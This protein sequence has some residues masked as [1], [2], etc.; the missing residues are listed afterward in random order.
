MDN[1]EDRFV[2]T[3]ELR[4]IIGNEGSQ[5]LGKVS[6]SAVQNFP[7]HTSDELGDTLQ[8]ELDKY[9]GIE[10][11][12]E[13]PETLDDVKLAASKWINNFTTDIVA[14]KCAEYPE[15]NEETLRRA[16]NHVLYFYSSEGELFANFHLYIK[17]LRM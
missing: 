17:A 10:S 1:P 15:Q 8:V 3:P 9:L 13:L 4:E 2:F 16:L 6:E 11:K 7:E 5:F 14:V 12:I